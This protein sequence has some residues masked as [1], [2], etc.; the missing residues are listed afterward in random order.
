MESVGGSATSMSF[1]AVAEVLTE[2]PT[3]VDAA[4]EKNDIGLKELE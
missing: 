2:A 3:V 1:S 4:F